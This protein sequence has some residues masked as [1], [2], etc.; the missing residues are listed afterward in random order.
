MQ[1]LELMTGPGLPMYRWLGRGVCELA[2]LGMGK[3]WGGV[4]FSIFVCYPNTGACWRT[5]PAAAG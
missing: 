3:A 5:M 2:C 1:G 4:G